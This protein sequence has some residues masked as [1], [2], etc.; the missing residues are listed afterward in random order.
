MDATLIP[1]VIA[2][3]GS[4][5]LASEYANAPTNASP[6]PV[7]SIAVTFGADTFVN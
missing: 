4:L 6:A 1:K 3:T 5:P 7:V 2:L